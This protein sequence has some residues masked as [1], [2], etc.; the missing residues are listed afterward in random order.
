MYTELIA[1]WRDGVP[2]AALPPNTGQPLDL[3]AG[4]DA[5][6]GLTLVDSSVN[7][8]DL[9][10]AG[11]DLLELMVTSPADRELLFVKD[12]VKLTDGVGRYSFTIVAADTMNYAGKLIYTVRATRTGAKQFV[13][14]P[15]YLTLGLGV[16]Q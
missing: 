3:P 16:P 11:A 14:T 2:D 4:T 10:L 15:S 5:V 9:D 6:L 8:V 7:L 12:A 1:V 13:L